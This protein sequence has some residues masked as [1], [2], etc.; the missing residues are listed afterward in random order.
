MGK[1]VKELDI[2]RVYKLLDHP[3]RK[4]IIELLGEQDRLG[5][6]ELKERL[7]INVGALYYH[8]DAL[9]DLIMQDENRK[10]M[11]TDLGRMAYQFL[12]SKK[13]QRMEIEVREK[14]RHLALRTGS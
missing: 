6:K 5:F 8:F 4:E 2:F 12:T 13:A 14:L 11:L 7:R 9:S 1:E 3:V 10:Y